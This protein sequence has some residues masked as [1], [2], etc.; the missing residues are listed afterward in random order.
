MLVIILVPKV[1]IHVFS[2]V[3]LKTLDTCIDFF[4]GVTLLIVIG[5]LYHLSSLILSLKIS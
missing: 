4:I 5:D 2:F 3:G 1:F